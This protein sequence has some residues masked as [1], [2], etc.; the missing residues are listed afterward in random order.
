MA[1]KYPIGCVYTFTKTIQ[2]GDLTTAVRVD[3]PGPF[4]IP[5][6]MSSVDGLY[7]ILW[8]VSPRYSPPRVL[9]DENSSTSTS[10]S[11]MT[12]VRPVLRPMLRPSAFS[13]QLFSK[14]PAEEEPGAGA[15]AE[16]ADEG[17]A[18]SQDAESKLQVTEAKEQEDTKK[19]EEEKPAGDPHSHPL[20][21]LTKSNGLAKSN[22][23]TAN[24]V[25][26][27]SSSSG[28]VFGQNVR[29]RV[30]GNVEDEANGTAGG[31]R[32]GGGGG[33]AGSGSGE[34]N[35][36]LTFSAATAENDQN[37][38]EGAVGGAAGTSEEG[39]SGK[40]LSDVAREYEENK[41]ARKR[42]FEEVETFTG[43]EDEI[44]VLDVSRKQHLPA[45]IY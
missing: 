3:R 17:K 4:L 14:A 12:I 13:S 27:L 26:A 1:R 39:G 40:S 5:K 28:F 42:K 45:A 30:T 18:L 10:S 20:A 38:A 32:G 2:D 9:P 29:D 19:K 22:P 41:N 15:P 21:L 23:F 36:D 25:T 7:F 37:M 8:I 6:A 16:Q 34:S 44:N 31:G 43:E 24:Q 33:G 35:G 11:S